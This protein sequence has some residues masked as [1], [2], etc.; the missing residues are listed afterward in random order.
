MN[1]R[2][3]LLH[4]IFNFNCVFCENRVVIEILSWGIFVPVFT[5]K[6]ANEAHIG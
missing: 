6:L 2:I 4:M 1:I 5:K 3:P